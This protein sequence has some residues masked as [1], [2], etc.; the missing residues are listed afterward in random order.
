M[1]T[2]RHGI[3]KET[4]PPSASQASSGTSNS[5]ADTPASSFSDSEVVL[6]AKIVS[7]ATHPEIRFL[8]PK[9]D[10]LDIGLDKTIPIFLD[11]P[12]Y[13]PYDGIILSSELD[14]SDEEIE[15][16]KEYFESMCN[17]PMVTKPPKRDI[18]TSFTNW[19]YWWSTLMC[20]SMRI[21]SI[22]DS[23]ILKGPVHPK[24]DRA[25]DRLLSRILDSHV[26]SCIDYRYGSGRNR[27]LEIVAKRCWR[28]P[29]D[30]LTA[31][32]R[33]FAPRPPCKR[34][35]E[36]QVMSDFVTDLTRSFS[37]IQELGVYLYL[38]SRNGGGTVLARYIDN[39]KHYMSGCRPESIW[40]E[41]FLDERVLKNDG[42]HWT[43]KPSNNK[44]KA[45]FSAQNN[46]PNKK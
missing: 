27:L 32:R 7:D 19:G 22:M 23:Y 35:E 39:K 31:A 10:F 14:L 33:A 44:R 16:L 34:K 42:F 3:A 5:D 37:S 28:G 12:C 29:G 2:N 21:S 38:A 9:Q 46:H 1:S 20:L 36:T 45:E 8:Q 26:D 17:S 6:K 24:L 11:R 41:T 15:D 43:K 4:T 18:L 25:L 40:K 13:D 30:K